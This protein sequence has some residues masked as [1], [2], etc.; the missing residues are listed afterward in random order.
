[1]EREKVPNILSSAFPEVKKKSLVTFGNVI[2]PR[3]ADHEVS[4]IVY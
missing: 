4:Y 1:M 3:S 2:D